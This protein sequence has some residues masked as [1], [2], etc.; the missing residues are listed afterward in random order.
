MLDIVY[1]KEY[2]PTSSLFCLISI[3]VC[4]SYVHQDRANYMTRLWSA[5]PAL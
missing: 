1:E 5:T 2:I 3:P 4:F